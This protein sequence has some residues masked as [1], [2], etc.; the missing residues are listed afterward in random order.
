MKH[1]YNNHMNID[2]SYE[3]FG[4]LY[5]NCWQQ[6]YGFL[7]DKDS[8]LINGQYRKRFNEFTVSRSG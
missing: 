7:I 6:K 8:A 1:V 2:M 5:R 3:D 4:E